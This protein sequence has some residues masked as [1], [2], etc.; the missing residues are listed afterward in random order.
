[1]GLTP[2][3]DCVYRANPERQLTAVNRNELLDLVKSAGYVP[4]GRSIEPLPGK[5]E[6]QYYDD[7]SYEFVPI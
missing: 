5:L 2:R 4:E 3:A 1:M 7:K 6:A